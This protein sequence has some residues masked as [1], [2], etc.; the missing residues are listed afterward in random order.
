MLRQQ[1]EMDARSLAR[2]TGRV[3]DEASVKAIV[4]AQHAGYR[5]TFLVYGMKNA[6]FINVVRAMSPDAV[7]RVADRAAGLS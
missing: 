7:G 3:F 6:S 1:A 4:D 5:Y 2:C